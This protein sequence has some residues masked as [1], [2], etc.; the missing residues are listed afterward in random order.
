MNRRRRSSLRRNQ[1]GFM[2]IGLLALLVMG[3]LYFFISNLTPEAIAILRKAKTDAALVQAREALVGYAIRYRE[4]QINDGQ[5]DRVYGYL[6]LPDLGSSR[7]NNVDPKCKDAANNPLEGCDAAS[8][9]TNFTVIGRFPWRTLGTE[10]LRDGSGECLWYVVSGSHDRIQRPTPMNWDTLGHLDV[11]TANSGATLVSALASAHN[12]PVAIIFSPGPP[13][14]GQNRADLGGDDVSQCGGNYNPANYLDPS[15]ALVQ[16]GTSAYFSGSSTID[17]STTNLAL[18]IS[19][20]IDQFGSDFHDQC[21]HGSSCTTVINDKGLTLTSD[22]LFG[23][24]RKSSSFRLEINSMLDRM[25]ACLRDQ[26]AAMGSLT[27]DA[28]SAGL[29]AS[30][31]DKTTGRI[32]ANASCYGDGIDPRGY[33]SNYAELV[34]VAKPNSGDFTVAVDGIN[35]S[36][37]GTLVFASQRNTTSQ[38]RSTTPEKTVFLNYLEGSN[39]TSFTSIGTDFGGANQFARVSAAQSASDDIVRCIPAGK[40]LAEAPSALPAGSELTAY[41]AATRTLTLGRQNIESDAGYPARTLFGCAW[42]PEAHGTGSGVRAY[43][44]FR[45]EDTGTPGEGFTF[46]A[47][48]GDRNGATVCGAAVQHMGYSGNNAVTPIIAHPKLG[49]E[50]DTRRNYVDGSPFG[51]SDPVGFDPGYLSSSPISTSHLNNGRADPNYTGGHM[52]IVY[53]GIEADIFSD[54]GCAFSTCP[55]PMFC[56]AVTSPPAGFAAGSYCHLNPEEDDNVHG[57]TATLPTSRPYPRNPV[58]PAA[59]PAPPAGVYKLDPSLSQVPHDDIHVRVEIDRVDNAGRDDHARRVRVVASS[60]LALSGLTTID[61]IVLAAGNRVLVVGQSDA[62]QNGVWIASTGAW[63]RATTENEGLEFPAGSSWFVN[64]GNA[65]QGS[66]WRLQ[67]TD[68]IVMNTSLINIARYRDPVRAVATTNLTRSGLQVVDGVSLVGGDRVLLTAQSTPSDN[69][70]YTVASGS[71]SRASLE[72]A[73]ASMMAGATWYVREGSNAGRFWHTTADANPGSGAAINI[74]LITAASNTIYFSTMT[75]KVWKLPDSPTS[76]NQI[77]KMKL[78]SRAL[79]LLDPGHQPLLSDTTTVYDLRGATCTSALTC[80]SGQFCGIDNN[81]YSPAFRT[82][83]LG[84]TNS[85]STRD[86]VINVTNFTTTWLP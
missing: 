56:K 44:K 32:P 28:N 25:A 50:F 66:L 61:T 5:L 85:Q 26:F 71:W 20:N 18:A 48:D 78:T 77:A 59:V 43:F 60:N 16:G 84:F 40:S 80:A 17:A 58:A 69:G 57:R 83:R 68:P 3:G 30:P 54:R 72:N 1:P 42:T 24:L 36:C 75:T 22:T 9:T 7:N 86:Q 76:A 6:P 63:S 64:E 73:S 46:A 29:P 47:I 82:M 10:P 79:A 35:Q 81:C 4:D 70:V 23:A 34:F 45:I 62:R 51:F 27:R 13:L 41:D 39:L 12:R 8:N 21:P 74:S 65:Y 11:V 19:G 49:I 33:F 52:A 2:L 55:S 15:T 67:N 37:A 14:A 38:S 31:A 53:W